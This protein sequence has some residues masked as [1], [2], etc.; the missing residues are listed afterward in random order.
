MN[1]DIINRQTSQKLGI[2]EKKVEQVNTFFWRTIRDTLYTYTEKPVNITNICVLYPT[3]KLVKKRIHE[4]IKIIRIIKKSKKFKPD[5]VRKELIL[6][7]YK[8]MLANVWKIR[9]ANKY[10]N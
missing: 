3:N 5:S 7:S 1:L 6:Q 10:T 4:L 8:I 9:K 2:D